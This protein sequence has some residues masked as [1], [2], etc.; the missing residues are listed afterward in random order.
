MWDLG[1]FALRLGLFLSSYAILADLIGL[2]RNRN[3]L[4]RSGRNATSATLLCL[5][6]A[7][8]VLWIL[9]VRGEFAVTGEFL[10]MPTIE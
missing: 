2:W 5:S 4:L 7:T 8:A 9:L 10:K 6:V 1:Q 3:E